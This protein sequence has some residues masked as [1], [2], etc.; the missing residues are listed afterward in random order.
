[1]FAISAPQRSHLRQRS[2]LIVALLM[3]LAALACAT[4]FDSNPDTIATL[5]AVSTSVQQTAAVQSTPRPSLTAPLPGE[6][7]ATPLISNPT[8][9]PATSAP[10]LTAT[11]AAPRL[12]ANGLTLHALPLTENIT[13]D[14]LL[15]EWTALEYSADTAVYQPEQ[16]AGADDQRLTFSLRWDAQALYLAARIVDDVVTQSQTGELIFRGDSLE[17]LFDSQLQADFDSAQLSADDFQIGL[18]PGNFG[19]NAPEA[20]LWFPSVR[21]GTPA[22]IAVAAQFKEAGHGYDLEAIVPWSVLNVTAPA[23]GDAF[24]F[25]LSASDNDNRDAA[26][27]QSMISSSPVRRLTDPT[28]WGTLVLDK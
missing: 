28:T 1:M 13:L 8:L 15:L 25:A 20:Y 24:G 21:A 17:W 22:A 14:G 4:P 26:E 16:W 6:A 23:A 5:N 7:S 27:Q 19:T 18:S 2:P 10:T 12:R 9:P 11:P 3:A